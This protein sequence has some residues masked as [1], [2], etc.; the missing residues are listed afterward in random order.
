MTLLLILCFLAIVIATYLSA[1][2]ISLMSMSRAA[3][4]W[5]LEARGKANAAAWLFDDLNNA[6]L[7][8]GLLRTFARMSIYVVVLAE[9]IGLQREATVTWWSLIGSGL[10][11]AIIVW[12]T[13][14]VLGTAIVLA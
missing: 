11:A 14:I 5:R 12:L 6:I 2:N 9:W 13:T 3:L 1:L 8:T 7:A 4:E 10:V